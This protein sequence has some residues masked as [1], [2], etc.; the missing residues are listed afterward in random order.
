MEKYSGITV[1]AVFNGRTLN[2]GKGVLSEQSI[3]NEL[4]LRFK[5]QILDL[6]LVVIEYEDVLKSLE[7]AF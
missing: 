2:L 3:K 1:K 4:Q 6:G 7:E 5:E